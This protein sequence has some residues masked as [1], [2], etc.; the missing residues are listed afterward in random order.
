MAQTVVCGRCKQDF[1]PRGSGQWKYCVDCRWPK[2]EYNRRWHA[3]HKAEQQDYSRQYRAAH[4]QMDLE[5]NLKR[6]YAIGIAD[7]EALLQAQGGVC[8]ICEKPPTETLR[9]QYKTRRLE[10]DHDHA[11]CPG[12][13]SCGKCIRGL[14][15][16][17]CNSRLLPA[18]ERNPKLLQSAAEY[19]GIP[20]AVKLNSGDEKNF[21]VPAEG[22]S[23]VG[24]G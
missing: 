18:I 17:H 15:C 8:A 3:L 21:G 13:K 2:A 16:L 23:R 7:Y 14:L 22:G 19:L 10:V 1:T 11:C 4:P 9:F 5:H 12:K 24:T 6:Y 20:F